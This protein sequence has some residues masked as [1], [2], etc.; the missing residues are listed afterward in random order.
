METGL[1]WDDF[2]AGHMWETATRTIQPEDLERFGEVS[3]DRNPLHLD[4]AYARERG[5]DGRIAHG[6]LGLAVTTGLV[7]RLGLTRGTLVALLETRWSFVKPLYP[8]TTV[9]VLL[10]ALSVVPT[11]RSDRGRVALAAELMDGDGVVYQRGELLLLVRRRAPTD[12]ALDT[13]Q[14]VPAVS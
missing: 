4:D 7:N 9:Q 13:P 1:W 6:V 10:T 3:G 5:F 2:R 12:P 14:V 11:R 8:G